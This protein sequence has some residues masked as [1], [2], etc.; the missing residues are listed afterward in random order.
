MME[1]WHECPDFID[2]K[3]S[4]VRSDHVPR[5][6][7]E[8]MSLSPPSKLALSIVFRR[9]AVELKGRVDRV[10]IRL[11]HGVHYTSFY[12]KRLPVIICICS[13]CCHIPISLTLVFSNCSRLAMPFYQRL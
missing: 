7:I 3:I 6:N 4:S 12:P 13:F 5:R 10:Y 9:L 2:D 11:R 8:S 1:S